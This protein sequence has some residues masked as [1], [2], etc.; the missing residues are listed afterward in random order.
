MR[1]VEFDERLARNSIP[2]PNSG[3]L[4]WTAAVA[5][6]G[7]GVASYWR[8]GRQK[9]E[10]AHRIAYKLANGSI[11]TGLYIC[12]KCDVRS[13]INPEHLFAGTAADNTGDMTRKGRHAGLRR[14]GSAHPRSKINE[15]AVRRILSAEG[16]HKE[17]GKE[18]GISA[19]NVCLIRGNKA[20]QHVGR[21]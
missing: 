4:L 1:L 16:T 10:Y 17:I 3:C 6:N 19:D 12:H 15:E 18:F 7:Y 9:T 8:G 11:P 14:K 2:E 21:G 13:C 5:R 20:W